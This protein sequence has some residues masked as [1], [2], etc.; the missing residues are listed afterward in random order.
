MSATRRTPAPASRSALTSALLAAVVALPAA[1]SAQQP[2]RSL[3][4][5]LQHDIG[6]TAEQVAA[7]E[8]AQPVVRVLDTRAGSDVAVFGVITIAIARDALIARL[9]DFPHS[10]SAPGRTRF[11]IFGDPPREADVAAVQISS[12]DVNELR[13]CRPGS[14]N[15]KI[16]A[17]DMAELKGRVSWSSPDAAA[18]VAAYARR[19]FIEYV[20]DY[21]TRGSAAMAVY[22]DRGPVRSADAFAELLGDSPYVYEYVPSFHRYLLSYPQGRLD[23]ATDVIF[24]SRDEMPGVRPVSSITHLAIYSPPELPGATVIGSKQIFADHYFEGAFELLTLI[25]RPSPDG[26]PGVYALVLRRYRFDDLPSGGL[27]NIKGRVT[28][29]L[30]DQTEA[31]LRRLKSVSEGAH[32]ASQ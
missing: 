13:D 4:S 22:A 8:R 12:R 20:A 15:F 6:F 26:T 5:F 29:K 31:D 27:L 32:A 2:Q 23:G 30:R 19:R 25:D 16:P 24:W 9:K 3:A 18:Q 14:C 17:T 10:L 7:V 21:R 1:A 11:G 28:R